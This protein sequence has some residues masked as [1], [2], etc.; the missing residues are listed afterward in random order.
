VLLEIEI[1]GDT[2]QDFLF[3]TGSEDVRVRGTFK[4]SRVG[5]PSAGAL[6]M[7]L[8]DGLPGQRVR[9]DTEKGVGVIVEPLNAP[10]HAKT[11]TTCAKLITGREEATEAD[12]KFDQERRFEN[13]HVP[14]WL[15]SMVKAVRGGHARVTAGTLPAAP[16]K[17]AK[18]RVFSSVSAAQAD[19]RDA[20][21]AQQGELIKLLLAQL[22]ADARAKIVGK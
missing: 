7:A 5:V 17:D 21:I 2:N 9:L 14:S 10:E 20:T 6:A 22:P 8:P 15:A 3:S 19:T 18:P 16:P 1:G 11:R 12:V 13:V 4:P